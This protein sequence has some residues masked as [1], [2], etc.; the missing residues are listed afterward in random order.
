M[1][2]HVRIALIVTTCAFSFGAA[3]CGVPGRDTDRATVEARTCLSLLQRAGRSADGIDEAAFADA[4][5]QVEA[6]TSPYSTLEP[7]LRACPLR[8]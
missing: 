6:S 7:F 5:R 8:G 3:A 1:S 2:H 4:L